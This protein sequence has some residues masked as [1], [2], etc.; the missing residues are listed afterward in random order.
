MSTI[1]LLRTGVRHSGIRTMV[2]DANEYRIRQMQPGDFAEI[3]EI[4]RRVY[5]HDTPYTVA[6][7]AEHHEVFPQGQFV[8][9]H[10]RTSSVAGVHFTLRL[11]LADFHID[12]P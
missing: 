7:L 11:R 5:P 6:E 1:C 2:Y 8:A 3:G 12:D 10:L 4:C 9:E